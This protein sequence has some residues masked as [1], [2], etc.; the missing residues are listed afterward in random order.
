MGIPP[1]MQG[2]CFAGPTTA[3]NSRENEMLDVL[4]LALGIGGFVVMLG[5]AAVCTRL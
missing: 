1:G 3:G 4:M 5:Y 2:S